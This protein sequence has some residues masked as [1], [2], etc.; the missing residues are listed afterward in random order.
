MRQSV[1]RALRSR[2]VAAGLRRLLCFIEVGLHENRNGSA[3]QM[4][5]VETPMRFPWK[6][7]LIAVLTWTLAACGAL[8]SRSFE[9]AT[10]VSIR[11]I[12]VVPIGTP[13]RTQVRIMNPIGAGFGV[14]GNLV[15]SRR[16]AGA[17]L[18]M[19]QVLAA[20][21]YDFRTSLA[22]SVAQAVSKVGFTINRLTG[23]RPDKEHSRFLTKYPAGKKVDAYLDVYATYVGFEAP[24]SSTAYRP[25]L[26]LSARLVS[27]KDH[28]ILFQD[29]IIYGCSENTDEDA[30]LVRADDRLSFRN[31]AALQVDPN[32]TARALQSAIDAA[33]WELAKQFM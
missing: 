25:R 11:R 22:N 27:A 6:L 26:E 8:P 15:E 24:Q 14:V 7:C 2:I 21:H 33:A 17:S 13:E 1:A 9:R 29:R 30:V 18:E 12:D 31:R 3:A 10:R 32:R 19:E 4:R 16:A 23:A 5:G 20:A 28:Q